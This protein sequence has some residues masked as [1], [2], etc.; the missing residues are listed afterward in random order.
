MPLS[1]HTIPTIVGQAILESLRENLV[2]ARAFNEDYL[3]DVVPGNAVKIPSIGAVTVKDYMTYTDMDEEEVDDASQTMT[4]DQQKY[5]NV[6]IDDIDAAMAKPAIMAAYA[7][8]AAFQLQATIDDYLGGVLAAGGAI[9]DDLGDET[10]PLDINSVNVGE[11]LRLIARKL[12]DAKT[13]RS[14]RFVIVP[15]W[16]V[17]DLVTANIADSTD[18]AG[19]L[20]EGLVARYAGFD[21]LMSHQTPNTSGDKWKIVAGSKISATWALAINKTEMLRH[22]KQFADIMRGLAVYGARVTRAA[23][24]AV[25][26]CDEATEPSGD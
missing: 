15:P 26:T 16:F 17:E 11:T 3:G 6:V 8:E 10:T 23:T 7:R 4:I 12:D 18:N 25:A 20:A 21:V 1:A 5:F 19:E 2:Y 9:T 14:G 24:I 22:P 13:P